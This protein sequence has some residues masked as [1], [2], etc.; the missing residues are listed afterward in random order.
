MTRARMG[1]AALT[2]AAVVAAA[3]PA[4]NAVAT[5]LPE[6]TYFYKV[7]MTDGQ[8]MVSPKH[9]VRPGS[10]V[11]F[12][13]RNSSS[14]PRNLIFGNYKTGF[15]GPGKSK[16]FELNFLVPWSFVGTSVE[17]GGGHMLRAKFICSW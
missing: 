2:A 1:A 13:V 11:V 5:T 14:R 4:S 17:R 15:I 16:Q 10:L 9:S 8:L 7:T 6:T 3:L 12:T